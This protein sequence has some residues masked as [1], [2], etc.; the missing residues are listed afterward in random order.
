MVDSVQPSVNP[1]D[2]GD[3][4]G[5]LMQILNKYL[6]NNIDDMIPARVVSYDATLQRVRVQPL[7]Q[8][9]DTAGGLRSREQI[10]VPVYTM[11]A[12]NA[13]LRFNIQ[14]D[15]LGWIKANDRD[16]SLYLESFEESAPNTFR[17]HSFADAVFFP[18]VLRRFTASADDSSALAVLQ[19]MKGTVRVSIFED[20][21]DL[22][23][24]AV[25]INGDTMIDGALS[26]TGKISSEDDVTGMNST[27]QTISLVNHPHGYKDSVGPAA[28]PTPE[29]TQPPLQPFVPPP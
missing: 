23:A 3:L 26:T 25:N 28:T 1:A 5:A 19:N 22:T 20:R 10:N 2:S 16:I 15:D 4:S 11:G 7:V 24:P 12:G 14:S 27:G 6:Q 18:D 21:L 13:L 8:I 9:M 29:M 17:K